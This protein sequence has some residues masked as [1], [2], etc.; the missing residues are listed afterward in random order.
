MLEEPIKDEEAKKSKEIRKAL[1]EHRFNDLYKIC[2]KQI[3]LK[4]NEKYRV[5]ELT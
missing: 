1:K 5:I 3:A 4:I 2:P